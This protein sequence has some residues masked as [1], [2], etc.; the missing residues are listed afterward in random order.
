MEYVTPILARGRAD[1]IARM[2][3]MAKARAAGES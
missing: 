2:L 1:D 3:Q